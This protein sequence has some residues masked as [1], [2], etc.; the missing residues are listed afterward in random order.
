MKTR[1]A[2]LLAYVLVCSVSIGGPWLPAVAQSYP[3]RPVK[4]VVAFPAGGPADALGR[5]LAEK[6]GQRWGQPVVIENRAGAGGN[7]GAAM[8]ART[9][10]DGYTLLLNA[11]SH[12]INASLSPT[13]AY[14]A[15]K[16]FTPISEL[17]SYMIVVAVHPS[18][19]ART[20]QEFVAYARA[21]PAGLTVANAGPGTPT[22]L[23][24]VLF[25][26]AAG[27][28]FVHLPYRGAAQATN[29]VLAGHVPAMFINP[30]N[31]VPQVKSNLLRVL[32]VTGSRRL[33]L[34]PDVPTIAELGY[35]GFETRTWFGLWGPAGIAPEQ[36][37]KVAADVRWALRSPEIAAKLTEQGWDVVA[38][39]PAEF[40]AVLKSEF[41]R[42]AAVI[43]GAKIKAEN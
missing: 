8:V 34:L 40:S 10:P 15:L 2:G 41:E 4:L 43:K 22:H 37:A 5:I 36:A 33:S 19:P 1:P 13:L 24:A 26:Q 32:A 16:D 38:S 6:L 18:V 17:A 14:D 11:S 3:D 35:P 31:A 25:A 30:V 20:L 27:V 21:Q 9:Q 29:D 28:D 23:A 39:S 42:W 7:V 12:V